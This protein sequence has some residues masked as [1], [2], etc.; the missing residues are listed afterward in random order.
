MQA[1]LR[2]T[3][4]APDLFKGPKVIRYT[5]HYFA[6]LQLLRF[7]RFQTRERQISCLIGWLVGLMDGWM[8]ELID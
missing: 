1:E 4:A 8:D 6:V 5:A 3:A 7:E 2:P